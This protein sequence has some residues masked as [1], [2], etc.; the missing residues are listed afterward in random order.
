[1]TGSRVTL[2]LL[3]FP[4]MLAAQG[5]PP[6]RAHHALVYDEARQRV[7]LTGGSS[8]Y[9]D[10]RCCAFFN[11]LWAFDGRQWTALRASGVPM[12]GMRLAYDSRNQRV[13]S[14]GG[15]ANGQ[16]LGDLRVL[17]QDTWT[18]I[19]RHDAMPA[20]EGGFVHDSRRGRFVAFGGSA[21]RGQAHGETW[22]YDG[23]AWTR[24][25]SDG[26]SP[27]QAFVMV[28]DERRGRT[29]V[30]GGLGAR[31]APDARPTVLGDLWE[32]DGRSWTRI[33]APQGP[34]ARHSAGATYDSRR[35]RIIVFGG[36]AGDDGLGDTWAWD[37]R[38]WARLAD[39]SAEGPTPRSMGHLAY[40]R[41]RDRVVLFGGRKG[42][43][44]DLDDTWEWDGTTWHRA[45]APGPSR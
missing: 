38:A 13:V 45:V 12:S 28:F 43:P 8:P 14:F 6:H 31:S 33:D 1:M 17:E 41:G 16:S 18:T 2:A 42:W 9:A 27:R 35:G 3:V 26:P 29:V 20:A 21:G 10:G 23:T 7:L 11:D 24:V 44:E 25:A 4:G 19:G 30:F 39:T 34:A 40:D 36:L 22:E 32:F 15:F 5:P 37:G